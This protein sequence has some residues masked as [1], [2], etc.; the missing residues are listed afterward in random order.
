MRLSLV[1]GALSLVSLPMPAAAAPLVPTG[2]WIVNFDDA[3]CVASRAYGE[4][5]LFLKA[6]P[7]GDVVQFGVVQPGRT[8]LPQQVPAE[9]APATGEAYR[10][11]AMMWTTS[12]QKPQRVRLINMPAAVFERLSASPTL[13]LKIG[14][15]RRDLRI[16]A[17]PELA[18]VMKTCVE[19]LQ[20]VWSA[21]GGKPAVANA[22]LAS[23]FTDD[24][25]PVD[26]VRGELSGTTGYSLLI[27]EHGRVAD[28]MVTGTSGQA[29]LDTQS[30]A[31]LK[32][33]ARFTPAQNKAG[34]PSKDRVT[35]RI[36][37]RIP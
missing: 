32:R 18:K 11:N 26:A 27:D 9:I 6:S 4:D 22:S 28:C 12:G 33:R 3:Q 2:R 7:A 20:R 13:A 5:Q 16:P 1:L 15:L 30:C 19:D 10:G 21:D 25:Y 23:Y 14:D 24:D 17:M 36:A 29:G 34:K 37:W 31:I 35:G 8:G